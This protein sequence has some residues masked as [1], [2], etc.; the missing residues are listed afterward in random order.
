VDVVGPRAVIEMVAAAGAAGRRTGI[1]DLIT[2]R[3]NGFND[4]LIAKSY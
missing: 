3:G 4:G 1:A 2:L